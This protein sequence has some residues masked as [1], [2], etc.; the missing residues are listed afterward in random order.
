[1]SAIDLATIRHRNARLKNAFFRCLVSRAR[2]MKSSV[3]RLLACA[4]LVAF[5]CSAALAGHGGG[6][7]GGH[8]GGGHGGG[9]HGGGHHGGGHHTGGHHGGGHHGGGHHAGRGG[10]HGGHAHAHAAHAMHGRE[11]HNRAGHNHWHGRNA[12]GAHAAWNH[13]GHN[14]NH[15]GWGWPYFW[16]DVLSFVFWP[17]AVYNPFWFYGP[18]FILDTVFWPSPYGGYGYVRPYDIYGYGGYAYPPHH[19]RHVAPGTTPSPSPLP[20]E[21]CTGLAPGVTDL[22]IDQIA[23]A[24]HPTG[25][26]VA[27]LDELKAASAKA[28]DVLKASCPTEVPLTPVARLDALEKRLNS[29]LQTVQIVRDPLQAFYNSLSDEQKQQFEKIGGGNAKESRVNELSNLC[30]EESANFTQ[31]PTQAIE[32]S[33]ELNSQQEPALDQLST[34]SS[35]TELEK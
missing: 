29:M 33:L 23:R 15:W 9:H 20:T 5:P 16:G 27:A 2:K 8:H 24:V 21:A 26:Q 7:G 19:H 14:W 30:S 25:D 6:H 10:H 18:S 17:Y 3:M 4:L 28:A 32:Q 34:A 11:A 35:K 1:M 31:L 13:G 12:F 22:P